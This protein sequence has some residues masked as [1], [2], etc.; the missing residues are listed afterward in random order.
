MTATTTQDH[1]P[2]SAEDGHLPAGVAW[3]VAAVLPWRVATAMVARRFAARELLIRHLWSPHAATT[4]IGITFLVTPL[5]VGA[6]AYTDALADL[7]RGMAHG[8]TARALLML[9]LLVGALIGGR[10]AGL[11]R[12]TRVRPGSLLRCLTGGMPM[13]WGSLL[14]PGGND[15]LILVGMPLLWPYAWIAFATMCVTIACALS[16]QR[17]LARGTANVSA[18]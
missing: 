2:V 1:R 11:F 17:R 12:H 15:G 7:A 9:C 5:L 3:V 13:G 14:I 8:V 10:T 4:V 18:P 6:W 16:L